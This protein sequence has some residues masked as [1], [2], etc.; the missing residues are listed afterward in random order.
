MK[1]K[2]FFKYPFFCILSFFLVSCTSYTKVPYLKGAE[3][4]TKEELTRNVSVYDAKIMPKDVLKITVN[5]ETPGAAS[6]FNISIPVHTGRLESQNIVN[7]SE[8]DIGNYIVD[9]KGCVQ[10]PVLGELKLAGLTKE[11]AESQILSM[12]YPNY[13]TEKPIVRIRFVNYSVSVLGE[14]AKPGIYKT[15]NEQMTIFDALAAAGDM[16]IYG[17]RNNVLLIR[18][19]EDGVF[20]VKRVDLQDKKLLLNK[21]VLY[22][23][24]NDKIYVEPNRSRA[25]SRSFGAIES[26][27][28]SV[29]SILI[30]IASII[31]YNKK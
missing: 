19:N 15:E 31:V 28:L 24:Q 5:S 22:L 4:L 21:E 8:G 20:D 12:I 18:A 14:V 9:S 25:N 3:K 27:S 17:K 7:V 26:V 29:I 23:Q 2:V 13:L 10:F 6:D 30:S 16:T 11:Q 1:K